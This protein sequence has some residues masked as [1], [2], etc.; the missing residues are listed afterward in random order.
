[1]LG[2]TED[3]CNSIQAQILNN[4]GLITLDRGKISAAERWLQ[5]GVR[6]WQD[7][8]GHDHIEACRASV[9]LAEAFALQGRY[10]EAFDLAVNAARNE[11]EHSRLTLQTL[12]E[13]EGLA[14]RS[15]FESLG[16][17]VSLAVGPLAED[18]RAAR[19]A[20]DVVIQ[21]R[22][23][24]LDELAGRLEA[25]R[26][27]HSAELREQFDGLKKL[28]EQLVRKVVSGTGGRD[29]ADVKPE[30]D[31]LKREI[32][33]AETALAELSG[34]FRR[35]RGLERAGF[36]EV[37][38][39]V[40]TDHVLVAYVRYQN[41]FLDPA[42][43]EVET[44][45]DRRS[46]A[47]AA[48]VFSPDRNVLKVIPL[49]GEAGIDEAVETTRQQ[50]LATA[51]AG[52]RAG[53]NHENGFRSAAM[54]LRVLAW[55]PI[56]PFIQGAKVALVVPDGN[57]GLVDLEFLPGQ[58]RR[59]LLESGPQV[60]YLSAERDLVR[61]RSTRSSDGLLAFGSPDFA[62]LPAVAAGANERGEP[63]AAKTPQMIFQTFRGSR[64]TCGGFQDMVFEPLPASTAEVKEIADLARRGQGAE[65]RLAA[66]DRVLAITG[67]QATEWSFK[68]LAPLNTWLHVATHGFFLGGECFH[69]SESRRGGNG[70]PAENPLVLSGLAFS[71]ANLRHLA[72]P[73]E[74]DGILTAEEI[75]SLDLSSV[76]W[77]VLSA[78]DTGM[79]EVVAGEGVFGLRRAFQ[80]AGARTLIMSLWPVDDEVTRAW[81]R[82]LYTNRFI[83]GMSTIDSV[84]EA[85]LVL[86]N[87]RREKG[88]S[89]HPFYWAGFIASGDWR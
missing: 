33:Q 5:R 81:M 64:A 76:E 40:P 26:L 72:S 47:Y 43:G 29:P 69:Q 7:I 16:L 25:V 84:H 15:I 41:V 48:F 37:S 1:M 88:L 55:D 17:I 6:A 57:L 22:A 86:L 50:V 8:G 44:R 89:T 77:A 13:R 66:S 70:V 49:A 75:A 14:F 24:L 18:P 23:M 2:G 27:A 20:W 34:P 11:I 39:V 42:S 68:T 9:T 85:S 54:N 56:E 59:Y 30:I 51:M 32:E 38:R 10:S 46:P 62:A 87:E 63:V 83:K 19:R 36:E 35:L 45:Q 31:E 82:E 71:G 79:G 53:P 65:N 58:D 80:I 74:D 67:A 78:C 61:G 73:D 21:Q 4:L 28:R 60:H 12:A 3:C 52:G